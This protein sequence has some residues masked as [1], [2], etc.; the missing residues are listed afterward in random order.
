MKFIGR[1]GAF[2]GWRTN[3]SARPSGAGE[4]LMIFPGTPAAGAW[5]PEEIAG[6]LHEFS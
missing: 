5:S 2:M 4:R 6:T 3:A 1:S